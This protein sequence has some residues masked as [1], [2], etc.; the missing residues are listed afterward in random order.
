MLQ[1]FFSCEPEILD[2]LS[3]IQHS[4]DKVWPSLSQNEQEELGRELQ[5]LNQLLRNTLNIAKS[6]R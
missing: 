5:E 1:I 3:Q 4:G 2:L 6:R